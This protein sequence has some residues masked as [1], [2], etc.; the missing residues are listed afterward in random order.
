ML[1]W[2]L[3]DPQGELLALGSYQ[4]VLEAGEEMGCICREWCSYDRIE[5]APRPRRGFML[6]PAAMFPELAEEFDT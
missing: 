6:V 4:R 2:I 3:V 5:Y 1:S